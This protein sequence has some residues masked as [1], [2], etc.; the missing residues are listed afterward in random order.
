MDI[1]NLEEEEKTIQELVSRL[2][3]ISK[4]Q[5]NQIIDL[6]SFSVMQPS[7]STSLYRTCVRM[8]T[9]SRDDVLVFFTNTLNLSI[10]YAT[11]YSLKKDSYHQMMGDVIISS[12]EHSR[13]GIINYKKTYSKDV[14]FCSKIETL[15]E[16]FHVKFRNLME[17]IH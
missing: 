3:F 12:L 11:R 5:I 16:T 15:L 9:E 14:M 1:G 10:E 2:K 17:L 4:I 13:N 8:G 7:I 6:K